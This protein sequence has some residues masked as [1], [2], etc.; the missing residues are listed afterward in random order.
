MEGHPVV[1][2]NR[3]AR[4]SKRFRNSTEPY[5]HSTGSLP[6]QLVARDGASR[7]HPFVEPLHFTPAPQEQDQ[8]YGIADGQRDEVQDL[9]D[10]EW[11]CHESVAP[12]SRSPDPVPRAASGQPGLHFP[13]RMR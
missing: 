9:F 4:V 8:D 12:R 7:I 11:E 3:A 1:A 2:P 10:G 5:G 13:L 6:F